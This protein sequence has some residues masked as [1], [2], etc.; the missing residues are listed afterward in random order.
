MRLLNYKCNVSHEWLCRAQLACAN[1]LID[2]FVSY[3]PRLCH[4][5]EIFDVTTIAEAVRCTISS[6]HNNT[7]NYE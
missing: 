5:R 2:A 4:Q 3:I 6:V 7:F 1:I